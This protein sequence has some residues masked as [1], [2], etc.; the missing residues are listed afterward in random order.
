MSDERNVA[1]GQGA[2]DETHETRGGQQEEA[3]QAERMRVVTISREYGSGGGEIAAR[4]AARLGW[5]LIDHE[6][7]ARVAQHLG[8]S[9]AAAEAHDERPES[10]ADRVLASLRA[11]E[12]NLPTAQDVPPL[13]EPRDYA[14]ALA[15]V[16]RGA[17]AAGNVVIVGRAAQV[18]LRERRDTLHVR[19]VAPPDWRIVYVM[20]RERLDFATAQKRVQGKD[21]DRTR[22]LQLRFQVHVEDAHLYDMV[23]N[24]GAIGLDACVELI[25]HTLDA[26][27][28]RLRL[29]VEALG[30]GEGLPA[31]P[32]RPR[33]LPVPDQPAES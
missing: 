3:E 23:L 18:L 9:L 10:R 25:A 16:V 21:T 32:E 28:A 15:Q 5:E 13:L 4:L 33:D 30:P 2:T 24:T 19:I 12:F 31:Y 29:P 6:V 7:V 26:K 8:V 27:A 1:G 17:A 11:L 14:D 20:G 22:Y